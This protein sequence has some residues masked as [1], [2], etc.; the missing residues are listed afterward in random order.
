MSIAM[1]LTEL[2]PN[3]KKKER[4]QQGN[5]ELMDPKAY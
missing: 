3:Q 1:M 2:P 5:H 4:M